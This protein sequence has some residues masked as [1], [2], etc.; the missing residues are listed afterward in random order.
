V[1]CIFYHHFSVTQIVHSGAR[2][3][4]QVYFTP[5]TNASNAWYTTQELCS[6][7]SVIQW[8]SRKKISV[9]REWSPITVF[10]HS[11]YVYRIVGTDAVIW[12]IN[13]CSSPGAR[14]C[15]GGK[16][17]SFANGQPIA[18]SHP[19]IARV[20]IKHCMYIP[21]TRYIWINHNMFMNL[22]ISPYSQ[23]IR[24]WP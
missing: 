3:H 14:A 19:Y 7:V 8:M 10:I 5:K 20:Y 13:P 23:M 22:R 24:A 16:V 4:V 11:T 6:C 15:V 17:I 9:Y 18:Q 12:R 1:E 21:A 2:L